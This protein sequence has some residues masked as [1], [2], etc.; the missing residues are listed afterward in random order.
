[1]V[2]ENLLVG[3]WEILVTKFYRVP[4]S[5]TVRWTGHVAR[6]EAHV[7]QHEGTRPLGRGRLAWACNIERGRKKYGGRALTG[8]VCLRS[9]DT[10]RASVNTVMTIRVP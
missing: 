6:M 10:W 9:R 8:F 5:R 1:V 4:K 2:D 3:M 7:E